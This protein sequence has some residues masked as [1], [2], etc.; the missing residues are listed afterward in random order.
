MRNLVSAV[1]AIGRVGRYEP[2]AAGAS[3]GAYRTGRESANHGKA[4]NAKP[5][6]EN[7]EHDHPERRLVSNG[8]NERERDAGHDYDRCA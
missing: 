7:E 5:N 4:E 6:H 8:R 3:S 2:A 1:R